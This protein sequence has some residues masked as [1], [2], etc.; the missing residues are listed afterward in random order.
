MEYFR[1]SLSVQESRFRHH[2]SHLCSKERLHVR[3]NH[4]LL[5]IP[6]TKY[7][8]Q[9]LVTWSHYPVLWERR[10][11]WRRRRKSFPYQTQCNYWLSWTLL[12]RTGTTWNK[13]SQAKH[14]NPLQTHHL[15]SPVCKGH[16]LLYKLRKTRLW[17][18]T[19]NEEPEIR[20]SME[21][22]HST[23]KCCTMICHILANF[24][25]ILLE[26]FHCKYAI[27]T[28]VLFTSNHD[29]HRSVVCSISL[30]K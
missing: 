17:T 3:S 21:I 26:Q 25:F 12:Q 18:R 14:C 1:L 24:L 7:T 4:L 22:I 19:K 15:F 5:Y 6:V 30:I 8:F 28:Q 27:S 9:S 13:Q 10:M 11:V 23:V 16:S 20:Y 2:P 29:F